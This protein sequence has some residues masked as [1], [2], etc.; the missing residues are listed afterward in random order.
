MFGANNS[1]LV[2]SWQKGTMTEGRWI[3]KDGTSW[4]GKFKN[5]NP[6][7]KGLFYFKNGNQQNGEYVEIVKEDAEEEDAVNLVWQGGDYQKASSNPNDIA[8]AEKSDE[9][10]QE[11]YE[12]KYEEPA[13]EE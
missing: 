11:K 6:F 12:S 5:N 7:G 1:Q 4:H 13:E 2:G 10:I 3:H 9:P 8:R